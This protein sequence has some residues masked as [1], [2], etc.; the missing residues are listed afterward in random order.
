M[1]FECCWLYRLSRIFALPKCVWMGV[2]ELV[3]G[4]PGEVVPG[5]ARLLP[6]RSQL[7]VFLPRVSPTTVARAFLPGR[8][9]H[10]HK[11]TTRRT[12]ARH[13]AIPWA[14]NHSVK[15]SLGIV[16]ELVLGGR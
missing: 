5:S 14:D 13:S 11:A 12:L 6:S 15:A 8:L 9:Y 7:S 10:T 4:G 3:L 1:F 16:P 2:P